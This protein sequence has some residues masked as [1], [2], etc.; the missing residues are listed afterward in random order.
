MESGDSR[1]D[2]IKNIDD[3]LLEGRQKAMRMNFEGSLKCY[4]EVLQMDPTNARALNNRGSIYHQMNNMEEALKNFEMALNVDST[5][6]EAEYGKGIVYYS[7]NRREESRVSLEKYIA[8]APPTQQQYIQSAQQ[9]LANLNGQAPIGD[10]GQ[11]DNYYKPTPELGK[12]I[13]QFN[14]GGNAIS[15]LDLAAKLSK[16]YNKSGNKTHQLSGGMLMKLVGPIFFLGL[17]SLLVGFISSM[18]FQVFNSEPNVHIGNLILYSLEGDTA[19]SATIGMIGSFII[20]LIILNPFTRPPLK[21]LGVISLIWAVVMII[22]IGWF[23]ILA[24]LVFGFMG[25]YLIKESSK[26]V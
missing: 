21:I 1:E 5:M 3:L 6:I 25:Y 10:F 2:Q 18:A 13:N 14:D 20:G 7:Q 12:L 19:L 4:N 23:G 24:A 8:N 17:I 26:Q 9:Y 16:E 15:Y 22:L 11:Q